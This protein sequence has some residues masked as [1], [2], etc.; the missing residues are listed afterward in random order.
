MRAD[1]TGQRFGR[2][3]VTSATSER[4]YRERV[5]ACACDC[6]E[7]KNVSTSSLRG[8]TTKSCG[9]MVRERALA[10]WA[11]VQA[12]GRRVVAAGWLDLIGRRFKRLLVIGL[13]KATPRTWLCACD[14][15]RLVDATAHQLRAGYK[16]SCGCLRREYLADLGERKVRA[17]PPGERFGRLV[18]MA[19]ARTGR[20]GAAWWTCQCDCGSVAIVRGTSLRAGTTQ[21]CGCQW[22]AVQSCAR[23]FQTRDWPHSS[24]EEI[25]K[26]LSIKRA[27][28]KV[29][30]CLTQTK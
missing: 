17:I 3:T 21:S 13:K 2:L 30:Q 18:V 5:W 22:Y 24:L 19:R 23:R 12:Q 28:R 16:P 8:G 14:C 1:L 9:C 25:E 26:Y 15:G 6:G 11:K 7:Q 27:T 4:Y 10:R 29:E 20:R